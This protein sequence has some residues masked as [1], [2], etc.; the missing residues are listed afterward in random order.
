MV[1]DCPCYVYPFAIPESRTQERFEWI[2]CDVWRQLLL[3]QMRQDEAVPTVNL[4]RFPPTR[5]HDVRS[6][7]H[8]V[9]RLARCSPV[10]RTNHTSRFKF[11]QPVAHCAW[12]QLCVC[13]IYRKQHVSQLACRFKKLFVSGS[14]RRP[15]RKII[16]NTFRKLMFHIYPRS[17]VLTNLS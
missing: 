12:N 9:R 5:G 4:L 10:Y 2:V 13:F 17:W 6:I 11:C 16:D 1:I 14:L 7:S 8:Q 3:L 15:C